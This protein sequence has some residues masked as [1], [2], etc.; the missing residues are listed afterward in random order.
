M[1]PVF[2]N[3]P[4]CIVCGMGSPWCCRH[5]WTMGYIAV[6]VTALLV[7]NLLGWR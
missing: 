7:M 6:V 2:R 4:R 5:R 3:T 1:I